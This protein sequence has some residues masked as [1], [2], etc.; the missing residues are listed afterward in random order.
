MRLFNGGSSL[1]VRWRRGVDYD[2]L[3]LLGIQV[4]M[5]IRI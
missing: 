5:I 3:F 1:D 2:G 4:S